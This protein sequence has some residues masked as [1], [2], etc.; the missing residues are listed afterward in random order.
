MVIHW[1]FDRSYDASVNYEG[2]INALRVSS[3]KHYVCKV[4]LISIPRRCALCKNYEDRI[5]S[6]QLILSECGAR[7]NGGWKAVVLVLHVNVL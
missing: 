7:S 5:L 2:I 3:L 1:K 6:S 4:Y